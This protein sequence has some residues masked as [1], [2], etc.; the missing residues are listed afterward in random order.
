MALLI[1]TAA[2]VANIDYNGGE[3]LKNKKRMNVFPTFDWD[4]I[5]LP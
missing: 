1:L 3:V 4:V 5:P 2:I